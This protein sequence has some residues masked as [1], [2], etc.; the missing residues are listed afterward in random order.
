RPGHAERR[1]R[2]AA[3][4]CHLRSLDRNPA[5]SFDGG[6][7][8]SLDWISSSSTLGGR[9]KCHHLQPDWQRRHLDGLLYALRVLLLFEGQTDRYQKLAGRQTKLCAERNFFRTYAGIEVFP[10][11]LWSECALSPLL[12]R[13]QT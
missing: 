4:Q 5:I 9:H 8:R 7:L 12:P 2:P 1:I 10:A 13:A 3:S 11:L 6:V